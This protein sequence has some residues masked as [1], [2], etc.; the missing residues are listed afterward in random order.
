M[1]LKTSVLFADPQII[2]ASGEGGG[3]R[4][5][6][7]NDTSEAAI[8]ASSN[9][10]GR[11]YTYREIR[12][13]RSW[14]WLGVTEAAAVAFFSSHLND[15]SG[16]FQVSVRYICDNHILK[17]Y[18]VEYSWEATNTYRVGVADISNASSDPGTPP[19][20]TDPT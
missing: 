6:A 3:S 2:D 16:L 7:V 15:S 5:Y 19:A 11:Q 18:T 8:A 14:R 20:P 10:N 13:G 9:G 12:F 17:S 1:A 4:T